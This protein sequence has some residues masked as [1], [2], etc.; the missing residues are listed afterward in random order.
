MPVGQISV[1]PADRVLVRPV[2]TAKKKSPQKRVCYGATVEFSEGLY[3]SQELAEQQM[4][5][6]I[7]AT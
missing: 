4:F 7:K 6:S 5:W 2:V 3:C 1:V